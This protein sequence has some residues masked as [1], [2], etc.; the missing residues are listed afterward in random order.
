MT[1]VDK[2]LKKRALDPELE[3]TIRV[4]KS[5]L[6]ESVISEL[7]SQLK[8]RKMVKARVNRGLSNDSDDRLQL[9]QM[10]AESTASNL[11]VT[12]GNIAVFHRK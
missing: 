7:D 12:R 11:I 8:S 5:G 9:W 10:L 4:G 2:R 6:T 1:E 3:V